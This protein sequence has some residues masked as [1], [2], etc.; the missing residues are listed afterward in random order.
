MAET[1]KKI[2]ML[3]A[4]SVGKT[5]LVRRYVSSL[6]SDR[7]QTTVGVKVDK[8]EVAVNGDNVVLLIWDVHGEDDVQSVRE[9]YLRGAS[10]YLLVA[11]GTRRYTLTVARNLQQRVQALLGPVPFVLLAN[12]ADV[13][14]QWEL[15][16][17]ELD[18]L[19]AAGWKVVRTSARTGAGVEAAFA[20][21]ARGL[22]GH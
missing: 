2:C 7:Y 19:G 6:F 3:G 16:D 10:G 5:S 13:P 15:R 4:F 11:D 21:L 8:K 20:L 17:E 12:K 9:A 18:E 1:K 22:L 14:D